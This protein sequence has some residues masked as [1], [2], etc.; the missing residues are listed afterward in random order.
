MVNLS[1]NL[2]ISCVVIGLVICRKYLRN[3]CAVYWESRVRLPEW[4]CKLGNDRPPPPLACLTL[5]LSTKLRLLLQLEKNY[6][7]LRN[8]KDSRE[9]FFKLS[10]ITIVNKSR[11]WHASWV[12]SP[13]CLYV[14]P[15]GFFTKYGTWG[16]TIEKIV[17]TYLRNSFKLTVS[18]AINYWLYSS[19][20]SIMGRVGG[21]P[22]GKITHLYFKMIRGNAPVPTRHGQNSQQLDP[23]CIQ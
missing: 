3:Y 22:P 7:S 6:G 12:V 20:G 16:K 5:T 18:T 8:G 15:W 9:N 11:G 13:M 1:I 23:P 14:W 19:D 4:I 21:S 17:K 10:R 2:L